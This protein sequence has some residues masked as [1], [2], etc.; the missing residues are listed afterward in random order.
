MPENGNHKPTSHRADRH[1]DDPLERVR[2]KIEEIRPEWEASR[3]RSQ[4]ALG[5]LDA[6]LK[7]HSR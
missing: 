1:D 4:R 6:A 7:L 3:E 2:K 5:E